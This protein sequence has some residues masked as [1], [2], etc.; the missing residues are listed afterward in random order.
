M[1]LG[2]SPQCPCNKVLRNL[3]KTTTY[4]CG[5]AKGN[6]IAQLIELSKHENF[7]QNHLALP[8][9]CRMTGLAH[10]AGER[11]VSVA[12]CKRCSLVRCQRA[13]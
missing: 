10:S 8:G 12:A 9:P 7:A 13:D 2:V 11:L 4:K 5:G 3:L 6:A 1:A